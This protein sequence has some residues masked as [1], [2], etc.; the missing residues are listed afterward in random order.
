MS[1][2]TVGGKTKMSSTSSPTGLRHR[3]NQRAAAHQVALAET[4]S[5]ASLEEPPSR[6]PLQQLPSPPAASG[7][8]KVITVH[9]AVDKL[10]VP[11]LPSI[12]LDGSSSPPPSSPTSSPS[13]T[14]PT[15]TPSSRRLP[16]CHLNHDHIHCEDCGRCNYP[17]IV[18]SRGPTVGVTSVTVNLL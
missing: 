16:L 5:S 3:R 10:D 8:R 12:N 4:A 6:P 1:I 11:T 15:P 9:S 17:D 13:P 18:A 2:T 7:R 14:T